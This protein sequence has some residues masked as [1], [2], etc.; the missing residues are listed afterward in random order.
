M[1]TPNGYS[2]RYVYINEE[3]KVGDRCICW[4]LPYFQGLQFNDKGIVIS[5]SNNIKV[6][7]YYRG[8]F[9]RLLK[10]KVKILEDG[11]FKIMN[12]K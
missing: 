2:Y 12:K 5:N 4:S 1:I 3:I 8:K 11:T 9:S 10:R 6:S 7:R